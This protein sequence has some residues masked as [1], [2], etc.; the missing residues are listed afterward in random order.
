MR[1]SQQ[2]IRE[3]WGEHGPY[4]QVQLITEVRILDDEISRT[5]VI[6]SVN[7]NPFTFKLIEKNMRLFKGDTIIKGIIGNSVYG[8]EADGYSVYLFQREYVDES[9]MKDARVVLAEANKAIIRMHKFVME[10]LGSHV[11]KRPQKGPFTAQRAMMEIFIQRYL[12]EAGK[13]GLSGIEQANA[14]LRC[15]MAWWNDK[16]S[17]KERRRIESLPIKEQRKVFMEADVDF[18]S[19][20]R[21]RSQGASRV[22]IDGP[23]LC[24]SGKKYRECC[25]SNLH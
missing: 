14:V 3:L 19:A 8:G 13:K 5:F 17:T 2:Q 18:L 10:S 16:L 24:G 9:V 12:E 22:D 11:E 21:G 4:S 7:I 23:C 1:L 25:R 6:V 20:I 15:V